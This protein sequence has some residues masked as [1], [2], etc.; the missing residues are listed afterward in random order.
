MGAETDAAIDRIANDGR[1]DPN[2]GS[3]PPYSGAGDAYPASD[4]DDPLAPLSIDHEACD[5]LFAD[6]SELDEFLAGA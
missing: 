5:E 2:L 4:D 3:P 6:A 1:P